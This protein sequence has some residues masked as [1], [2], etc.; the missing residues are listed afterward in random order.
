M[1]L[2]I[3]HKDIRNNYPEIHTVRLNTLLTLY[4]LGVENIVYQ[5][6]TWKNA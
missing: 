3:T 2:D 1:G 4:L 6:H 5:A